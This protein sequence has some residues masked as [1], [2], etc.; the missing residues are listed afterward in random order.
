MAIG[1][2]ATVAASTRRAAG[3]PKPPAEPARAAEENSATVD[4]FGAAALKES[5]GEVYV[6]AVKHCVYLEMVR[7]K[8]TSGPRCGVVRIDLEKGK[9]YTVAASGEAFMSQQ[10][11]IDADPFPGVVLYYGVDEEDGY[12]I[13]QTVLPS[14]RSITFRTPWLIRPQD[15]VYLLAFF[16]S[17]CSREDHRGSYTLTVTE[18]SDHDVPIALPEGVRP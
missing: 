6:D 17:D 4:R 5:K 3:E 8:P 12:A 15:D 10:Q 2:V 18:A 16:L 1:I 14:G 7:P 13:R 11:G 9:T